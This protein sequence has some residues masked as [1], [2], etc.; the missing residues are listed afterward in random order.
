MYVTPYVEMHIFPEYI[1]KFLIFFLTKKQNTSIIF[2]L[3]SLPRYRDSKSVTY[4]ISEDDHFLSP[5]WRGDLHSPKCN[6]EL[7]E[8]NR[9]NASEERIDPFSG[10]KPAG[11]RHGGRIID[12][13]IGISRMT[14]GRQSAFHRTT[15]CLLDE[16]PSSF[17]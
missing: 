14:L 13:P 11:L 5:S 12:R 9:S 1:K 10:E 2:R 4:H 3:N 6:R 15:I 8:I 16:H 7:S 17:T